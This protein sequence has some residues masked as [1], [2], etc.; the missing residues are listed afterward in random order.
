MISSESTRQKYL[1]PIRLIFWA[2]AIVLGLAQAWGSRYEFFSGDIISY[3]EMGEAYLRGDWET[4]IHGYFSPLYPLILSSFI[5]VF[6]PSM[7]W[8]I[9]TVK[10]VNFLIYLFSLVGFELFL[11]EFIYF[12]QKKARNGNREQYLIPDWIWLI[13]GYF[14]FLWAAIKWIGI[15]T[16]T[17]DM[18]VAGFVYLAMGIILRVHARNNSW[19]NFVVFG[20]VLG[21]GYLAK[22]IMLPAALIFLVVCF[23]SLKRSRK[24]YYKVLLSFLIFLLVVTPL[25]SLLSY[26][27][28]YFTF[29]EAGKLNRAFTFQNIPGR[30][31][32]GEPPGTGSP[33]HPVQ[34]LF[35][36]PDVY[37]F[38]MHFE[39]AT[40]PIGY[41][42][43][44]WYEGLKVSY[45]PFSRIIVQNFKFYYQH[46]FRILLFGYVILLFVSNKPK[47]SLVNLLKNWILLVPGILILGIYAIGKDFHY[48]D[49]EDA[50]A[51]LLAPFVVVL[52]SG[53][54]SSVVLPNTQQSKKLV[55]GFTVGLLILLSSQLTNVWQHPGSPVYWKVAQQLHQLGI[56]AGDEVAVIQ[57]GPNRPA[58]TEYWARL[59][60]VRIV[61]E[62][63]DS[64]R[65]WQVDE[66]VKEKI[67]Q[68]VSAAGAEAI[69]CKQ[70]A[71]LS[72]STSAQEWTHVSDTDYYVYLLKD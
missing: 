70:N 34:K 33:E 8:E 55:L 23:L 43:S 17:P 64:Y 28:G 65:F 42:T 37:A 10:T 60:K 21:L 12:Y 30:Y 63:V 52:F 26:Q 11:A 16:D 24:N 47:F 2:V 31:W 44:F 15:H 48:F 45:N 35:E 19:F 71:L 46:F 32:Q 40:L 56:E 22:T 7:Y 5:S 59:A 36:D 38:G 41:D 20:I 13:L 66:P 61:A 67:Y 3:I 53:F 6:T 9:F 49:P 54:F 29:G 58:T 1:W 4:A 51:R 39:H 14:L 69:V 68:L 25:I 18:L 62:I 27:K 72:A 57:L 50:D